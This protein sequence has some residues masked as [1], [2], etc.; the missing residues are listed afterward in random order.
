MP[1]QEGV[2]TA[3]ISMP[4]ADYG[5]PGVSP[6]LL[7]KFHWQAGCALAYSPGVAAKK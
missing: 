7:R 3:F 6:H 2:C 4:S 5:L 1:L